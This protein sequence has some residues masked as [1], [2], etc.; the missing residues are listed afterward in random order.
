MLFRQGEDSAQTPENCSGEISVWLNLTCLF[1]RHEQLK[2]WCESRS[3]LRQ[4]CSQGLKYVEL[5][6]GCHRQG[7]GSRV[8]FSLAQRNYFFTSGGY[9]FRSLAAALL[10][11]FC[12]FSGLA[13]ASSVFEATPRH[14]SCFVPGSYMLKS[15][16]PT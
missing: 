14:M 9:F 6:D 3:R 11:F 4:E 13:L 8:Q 15:S 10:M 12:F 7:T 2:A 16:W 1:G 5:M